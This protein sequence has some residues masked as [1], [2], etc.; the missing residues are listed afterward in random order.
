MPAAGPA[1][2]ASP[3]SGIREAARGRPGARPRST[4]RP[5]QM[6]AAWYGLIV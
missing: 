6:D 1:R 4:R 5:A 2:Q 3:V